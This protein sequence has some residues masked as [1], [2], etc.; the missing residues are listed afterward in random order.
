[1]RQS[2]CMTSCERKSRCL[3]EQAANWSYDTKLFL[4]VHHVIDAPD[5]D[6][7]FAGLIVA[8][9]TRGTC[10]VSAPICALVI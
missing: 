8:L 10:F 1:M 5:Q 3:N 7:S 4:S 6:R 2:T 9:I